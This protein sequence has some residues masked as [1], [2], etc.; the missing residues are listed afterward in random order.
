[1]NHINLAAAIH[2]R[3]FWI[4]LVSAILLVLT[5]GFGMNINQSTVLGFAGIVVSLLLGDAYVQ[6]KHATAAASSQTTD[7]AA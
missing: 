7:K 6:A 2:S 5:K 4:A 3:R 1:M